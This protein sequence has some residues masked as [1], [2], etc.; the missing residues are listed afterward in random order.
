VPKT[1]I[2]SG[3]SGLNKA[4]ILS[5]LSIHIKAQRAT[6]GKDAGQERAGE[7]TPAPESPEIS[8]VK[9]APPRERLLQ[10]IRQNDIV[11]T[12]GEQ[13]S[14]LSLPKTE[15]L[16]IDMH[17]SYFFHTHFMTP[18][19]SPAVIDALRTLNPLGYVN[20]IDDIYSIYRSYRGRYMSIGD[21]LR[22]R[23]L[24]AMLTDSV[25]A[26]T[27]STPIPSPSRFDTRLYE[28]SPI[29]AVRHHPKVACA[30]MEKRDHL[31]VY[32]SFPISE[33]RRQDRNELF[34]EVNHFRRFLRD[35]YVCFDPLTI[36]E[37]PL[38]S[39]YEQ[40]VATRDLKLS[41]LRTG[42]VD[43]SSDLRWPDEW[44]YSMCGEGKS[45]STQFSAEEIRSI[46]TPFLGLTESKSELD[47]QAGERDF[48]LIDQSDV[49]IVYR[50]RMSRTAWSKGTREEVNYAKH[51]GKPVLVISETGDG[52]I[53]DAVVGTPI[54]EDRILKNDN[55][56]AQL[57]RESVFDELKGRI[58]AAI[59]V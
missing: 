12:V 10:G 42:A 55:L 46:C 44:V 5:N 25:A 31:R 1:F 37:L 49:V 40:F 13:L 38:E 18:L 34:E 47:R 48:R 26:A 35:E 3:I 45:W 20:F 50:P 36:D 9:I 57:N 32:A 51:Q 23:A 56:S 54:P 22:W 30:F 11:D 4:T 14:K 6:L 15:Y 7:A 59:G 8:V 39:A 2:F 33:P 24:E 58:N 21:V 52:A 43:F 19:V 29:I 28:N 27:C 16:L 17:L 41:E 53:N